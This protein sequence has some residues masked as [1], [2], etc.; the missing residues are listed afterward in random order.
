M[1]VTKRGE[2][3]S[4]NFENNSTVKMFEVEKKTVNFMPKFTVLLAKRL[5]SLFIINCH[6]KVVLKEDLQQFPQLR[7]LSLS[8]NDLEWLNGDLFDYNPQLHSV[9]F[10]KNNLKF[11]GENLVNSLTKLDFV[12]F[13]D[14]GCINFCV[15]KLEMISELKEK[16]KC[17]CKD[18]STESN[19][20]AQRHFTTS[21]S[22]VSAVVSFLD[23]KRQSTSGISHLTTTF[24]T[25]TLTSTDFT[26]RPRVTAGTS[27]SD[28]HSESSNIRHLNTTKAT[29]TTNFAG[30]LAPNLS[31]LFFVIS[32]STLLKPFKLVCR[33]L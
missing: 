31:N 25:P 15:W 10:N 2:I 9:W 26:A 18:K 13:M 12:D 6:L 32:L 19:M 4:P 17:S 3:M 27:F 22:H 30:R 8:N 20:L 16:L 11:I 7:R 5:E 14:A 28:E 21:V 23:E 1:N 24:I 29:P 33:I